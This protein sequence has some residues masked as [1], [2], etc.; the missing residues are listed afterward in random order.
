MGG[1]ETP[2]FG[3]LLLAYVAELARP[4]PR[5]SALAALSILLALVRPEGAVYGLLALSAGSALPR[6]RLGLVL[7]AP[8][9]ALL[10]LTGARLALTGLAVP[11]PVLAKLGGTEPLSRLADGL[12]YLGAF[13][14]ASPLNTAFLLA[15]ASLTHFVFRAGVTAELRAARIV[16]LATCF[17]LALVTLGGGDWMTFFRFVYPVIPL[18]AV[19]LAHALMSTSFDSPWVRPALLGCLPLLGQFE[20]E[21][22]GPFEMTDTNAQRNLP[23]LFRRTGGMSL[24]THL[25]RLNGPYA[26]DEDDLE[27]FL[28]GP[29]RHAA[30]Q[31]QKL[32]LVSYQ[33]GFMPYRLW[34]L[35]VSVELIDSMGVCDPVV[36]RLPGPRGALGLTEGRSPEAFLD[37]LAPSAL[38]R[39]VS[40]KRPDLLYTLSAT[41]AQEAALTR[42]GYVAVWTRPRARVYARADRQALF[43]QSTG[44]HGG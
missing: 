15:L 12:D 20:R 8:W 16:V 9:A 29:L 36:A 27:P 42:L 2:L 21:D 28:R 24:T 19:A 32:T 23:Q 4:S 40:G 30:A 26:R 39:Y 6:A 7:L 22:G 3:A 38:A 35:G 5:A 34:Q 31:G 18:L 33:F 10:A 37:P 11:I 14:V 44:T 43:S 17:H 1:L 41:E 13:W 25:R